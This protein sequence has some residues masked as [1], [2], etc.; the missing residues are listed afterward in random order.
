V[1][2]AY[3][4]KSSKALWNSGMAI[5]SPVTTSGI[6]TGSGMIYL[7]TADNTIYAFGF[8]QVRQ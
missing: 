7:A 2:Y 8:P 1:L 5:D 4:A 6:A 3:D